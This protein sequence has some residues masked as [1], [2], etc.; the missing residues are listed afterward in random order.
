MIKERLPCDVI[1]SGIFRNVWWED[2][3]TAGGLGVVSPEV[4]PLPAKQHVVLMTNFL[5]SFNRTNILTILN[6]SAYERI[7]EYRA[8]LFIIMV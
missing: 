7:K 3:Y 1:I 8:L 2:N 6:N 4:N 5:L